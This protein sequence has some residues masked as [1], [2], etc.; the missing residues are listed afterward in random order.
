MTRSWIGTGKL[1]QSLRSACTLVLIGLTAISAT[2]LASDA[3]APEDPWRLVAEIPIVRGPESRDVELVA[4]FLDEHRVRLS[5]GEL[6]NIAESVAEESRR[7]GI[8]PV[9]LLSV[10]LT[11]SRFRADAVSEKGAIGLMQLLPSTAEGVARELD[12]DWGGDVRLLDPSTNIALGSYYLKQLMEAFD[13]DLSL[14]LTAYNK[15]PG[16]VLRQMAGAE[17][18]ASTDLSSAYADQIVL[19]AG[20]SLRSR[21]L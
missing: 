18:E 20:N 9:L 6:L 19:H 5:P 13:D 17:G 12:L 3:W 2:A 21:A 15:G 10:I 1:G 4:R 14:A 16:Y 11:E 8:D 7:N